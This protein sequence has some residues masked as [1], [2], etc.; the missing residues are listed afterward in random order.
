M[1][2]SSL[3]AS[4]PSRNAR[5]ESGGKELLRHL[6]RH[7]SDESVIEEMADIPS[8]LHYYFQTLK[9]FHT[10]QSH[11]DRCSLALLWSCAPASLSGNEKFRAGTE[12]N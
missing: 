3:L 8:A 10:D 1:Q 2:T 4:S 7:H 5:S 6:S 12:Q 11:H 9:R